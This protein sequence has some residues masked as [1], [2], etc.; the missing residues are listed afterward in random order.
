MKASWL[1]ITLV[2]IFTSACQQKMAY[3]P[4]YKTATENPFFADHNSSRPLVSGT[5][6]RESAST[7]EPYST[8]MQNGAFLERLPMPTTKELV[9]RGR[10]RFEIYCAPCHGYDGKGLGMVVTRGFSAP[11][12]FHIDRL[13]SAPVGTCFPSLRE[14]RARCIATPIAYRSPIVGR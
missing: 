1:R 11:P 9:L 10:D 13:R 3:G 4:Y 8:G 2:L 5:V 7:S 12:S 14:E 6:S